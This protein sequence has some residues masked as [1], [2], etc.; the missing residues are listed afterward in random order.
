M[1]ISDKAPKTFR[2]WQKKLKVS[3]EAK[4][5]SQS[6]VYR[7]IKMSRSTWERRLKDSS[8]TCDEALR[9]CALLNG[10]S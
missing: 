7:G 8:F 2:E 9:I 10:K 5:I 4:G 1:V 3:L 6:H